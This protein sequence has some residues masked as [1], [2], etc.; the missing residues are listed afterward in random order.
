MLLSKRTHEDPQFYASSLHYDY[1]T[2]K[3]TI[4]IL[5]PP[6][7]PFFFFINVND[8]AVSPNAVLSLVLHLYKQIQAGSSLLWL[9]SLAPACTE[10]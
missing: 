9:P 2:N 3:H 6:P 7:P 1:Y 10:T 4:T 8:Q 5:T